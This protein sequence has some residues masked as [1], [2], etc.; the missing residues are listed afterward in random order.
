MTSLN[1]KVNDERLC[2]FKQVAAAI[3]VFY[4]AALLL[5]ADGL[6]RNAR[7]LPYGRLHDVAVSLAAPVAALGGSL[8]LTTIRASVE[9]W[10]N[11]QTKGAKDE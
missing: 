6:L 9:R 1:E 4:A 11:E 7:R 10:V 2:P 5:N 8:G 3:A